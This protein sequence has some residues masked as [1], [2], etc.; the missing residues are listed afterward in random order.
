MQTIAGIQRLHELTEAISNDRRHGASELAL[1][2]L[3]LLARARPVRNT[4]AGGYRRD[5]CRLAR[6]IG[7]ARPAMAPIEAVTTKF[8]QRFENAAAPAKSAGEIHRVVRLVAVELERE[9]TDLTPSAARRFATRFAR[10]RRPLL[11]SYSSQ[12]IAAI[13]AM[14]PRSQRVTVCESRPAQEGRRTARL[15]AAVA[16]SVTV[17]TE[18]QIGAA[19]PDCD[20]ALFGCDAVY[21]DGSVANK[22]GSYLVALACRERSRP[23]IVVGDRFKLSAAGGDGEAHPPGEV[24]KNPPPGIRVSN[25]YFERVPRTLIDYVV[26]DCGVYRPRDLRSVWRKEQ[27][28]RA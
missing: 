12:V 17:I 24:W 18:A 20:C 25:Q 8:L 1:R 22:S 16:K 9:L 28:T 11:I 10:I 15:L 27:K 19:A 7:R 2:A 26:L 5:V 21:A 6:R 23:V 14:P 3:K 13:T 4:P